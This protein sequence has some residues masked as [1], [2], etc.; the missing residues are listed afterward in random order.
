MS[1]AF[2]TEQTRHTADFAIA[3]YRDRLRYE[4]GFRLLSLS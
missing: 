1:K 2:S 4:T 3:A